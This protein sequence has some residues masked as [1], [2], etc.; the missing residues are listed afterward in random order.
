MIDDKQRAS[1]KVS[2][3]PLV[4]LIGLILGAGYFLL[5]GEIN[6]PKLNKGPT[7][8]RIEGFPTVIYSDREMEK[9][10]KVITNE[11][12]LNEFLNLVDETGLLSV[13]ES[14]N[15]DKN[16]VLAV[17][18]STN[19]R[20]GHKIKIKS[21]YE[22]KEDRKI[23]VEFEE[24]NPDGDCEME[25]DPNITVDMV[26]LSKTDWEIDFEKITKVLEC[27]KENDNQYETETTE[28]NE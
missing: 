19:D 11:Q 8:Q 15:F 1:L 24:M 16:I 10:R 14:I 5:Q 2:L 17:A 23:L 3:I 6:L 22:D 7:I 26:M 12:E 13:K 25:L 9:Q 4:I 27:E 18:S 21:L 28:Q 20:V